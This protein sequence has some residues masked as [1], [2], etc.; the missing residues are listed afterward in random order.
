V[1]RYAWEFD[2]DV[3]ASI[4]EPPTG[5]GVF[6]TS[7]PSTG[8]HWWYVTGGVALGWLYFAATNGLR[9]RFRRKSTEESSPDGTRNAIAG[10]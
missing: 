9:R 6:F 5:R 4:F 3:P 8:F 1:A 10:T 7:T 2:P